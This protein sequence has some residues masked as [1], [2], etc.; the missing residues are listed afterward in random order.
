MLVFKKLTYNYLEWARQLHNDPEVISMLTDPHIVTKQE[1]EKWFQNLKTSK[2]SKRIIAFYQDKPIGLI[3]LDQIDYHNKSICIG[4]DIHQDYRGK[5]FAKKIYQY[6]FDEWFINA[7][8]NR[9]WL[10][11]ASYNTIAYGLYKKL[12]FKE[13][14]IQREALYKNSKF[15]DYIMMS[16]LK[17]EYELNDT[18]L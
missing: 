11:V 13:E 14:G 9:I 12:G 5:G 18:S 6:I 10:L 15:H 16:I 4:L 1:Q 8:F 2:T 17:K 3:R 7:E